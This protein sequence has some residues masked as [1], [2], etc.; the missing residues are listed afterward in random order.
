MPWFDGVSLLEYLETVDAADPVIDAPFRMAVQRV[1]RPDHTFRGYA[2]QIASGV[3]HPGDEIVRG[4]VA[5]GVGVGVSVGVGE[6]VGE[7]VGVA[8]GV[9]VGVGVGEG[10]GVGVGVGVAGGSADTVI[11]FTPAPRSLL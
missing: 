5:D 8:A 10:V 7:G 9:G 3:V 11:E 6:S 1:V 4:D 2:G